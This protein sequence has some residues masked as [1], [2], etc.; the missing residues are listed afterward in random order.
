MR[1]QLPWQTPTAKH[2]VSSFE[3]LL[4]SALQPV[5]PEGGFVRHLRS[6]LVGARSRALF[7]PESDTWRNALL[8]GGVIASGVFMVVA[9]VRIVA[10]ILAALGLLQQVK[11]QLDEGERP[12]RQIAA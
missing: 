8:I 4:E 10:S 1:I 9:G 12:I 7:N 6:Q 3:R 5:Q 2:K 11:K